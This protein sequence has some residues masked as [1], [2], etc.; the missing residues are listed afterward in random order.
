MNRITKLMSFVLVFTLLALG[1]AACTAGAGEEAALVE[2]QKAAEEAAAKLAA[3]QTA[4]AEAEA[5][6]AAA[7]S[8]ESASEEEMEKTKAE[9]DALQAE[10]DAAKAAAAEAEEKAAS[11]VN[12]EVDFLTWFQYDE[13]NEDPA[14]DERVGNEYL[15]NTIPQFNEAFD[16]KWNWVNRFKPWDR[17]YQELVSAVIAGNTVPDIIEMGSS[18]LNLVYKNGAVQDLRGWA[19]QQSWF[20]DMDPGALASCTLPDGGLYCIPLVTRPHLV[21]V[22]ADHYPN[23]FPKTPEAFIAEAERLKAEGVYAWTY[24]GST[25]FGGNGTGRMIWSL[26]SSFG[27]AYDDGDGNLYLTSPETIAAIEFLRMTVKEGYN[28]ETVFAGGF[29]E[30]DS[31]KDASAAAIPTGLFGYRYINP[32][33][34]PDSTAYSKG[35]AEDM[36][37]AI[38]AGDVV[39]APM[40]APEGRTPGCGNDIQGLSIP[41]GAKN[42]EAAYDFI[43][44]LMTSEQNPAF[45][46]G[47]GAGFPANIAM[48]SAPE[49]DL[50]FYHEAEKAL[51]NSVCTPWYGSLERREEA[52]ETIMNVVYKLIKEN[53][54]ADILTELQAAEV[55]YNSGN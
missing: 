4:L 45:V 40:F 7:Q 13:T 15:R 27:G 34:A 55:E 26:I 43:N 22:W 3:A 33:T 49:L 24:F 17:M 18:P 47:P 31:F 30:E 46:L 2:A 12:M 51:E 16:G 8:E 32:L 6:A 50:P 54:T 25:A 28:P 21:Y 38:A 23:G 20:A 36:L 53:P 19:E 1:S 14:S 29:V 10:L 52:A 39:L 35:S 48:L 42:V 37:D 44:W 11:M 9:L 5:K 41:T